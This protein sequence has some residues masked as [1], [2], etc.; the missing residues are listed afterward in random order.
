MSEVFLLWN[1]LFA[2]NN[3]D[4]FDVHELLRKDVSINVQ[5]VNQKL[6]SYDLVFH[7]GEFTKIKGKENHI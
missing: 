5:L 1:G 2:F 3:Y 4:V 7:M 6:R